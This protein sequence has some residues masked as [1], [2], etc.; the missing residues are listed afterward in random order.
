[1]LN[2]RQMLKTTVVAGL[3]LP[4]ISGL[5]RGDAS[6]NEKLNVAHIGLGGQGGH[7]LGGLANQNIV[8]LCDCDE[9]R[10]GNAYERFSGAKA[11]RDYRKMFD[12][13]ANNIDAVTVNTPDHTHFHPSFIALSL[14]K[15]LY[16]EKP[17]AHCVK[18]CRVLAEL[19][20]E[21]KRATQLGMQRHALTGMHR[22]VEAIQAGVIGEVTEVYTWIGGDRGMPALLS[23]FPD[24]PATLDWELWVGP[25]K[26]RK[27]T[28]ELCPYNW[29]FWWDYGTGETGNWCCHNLD[30]PFWALDLTYPET[31]SATGPE[32]DAERTSKSMHTVFRFPVVGDRKTLTLHWCH[33]TPE[34][35]KKQG[36]K[37]GNNLFVGTKGMLSCDFT[38]HEV[39]LNDKD[40]EYKAPEKSIPDSPGFH[41]EWVDACKGGA[42]AT[43]NFEYSAKIAELGLLGNA[44][45][46]AGLKDAVRWNW[47]EMKSPDTT[48]M[49]A[50]NFPEYREG[51]RM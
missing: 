12:E 19:A 40:T 31:V 14:D 37:L 33:G 13:M 51:W 15:H 43:C 18:E 44:A 27:Y 46:R 11:F 42:P 7:Q 6:P 47:Q 23:K 1:M 29:R 26:F 5:A 34:F 10:A 21:K 25:A 22:T 35:A 30:I 16:L 49:D 50:F 45:Y 38:W 9:A 24:V 41:K 36:F 20:R 4:G 3:F 28:P 2:R 39:H 48:A 17:M 8:A 32:V